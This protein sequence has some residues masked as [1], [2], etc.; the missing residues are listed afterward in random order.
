MFLNNYN[1]YSKSCPEKSGGL[2]IRHKQVRHVLEHFDTFHECKK[3]ILVQF[4]GK[5]YSF[6]I[7]NWMHPH[8]SLIISNLTVKIGI[9]STFNDIM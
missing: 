4:L 2:N 7:K 1:T 3:K 5:N 6:V 8:K 9:F